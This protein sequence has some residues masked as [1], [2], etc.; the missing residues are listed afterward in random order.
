MRCSYW[1]GR[2]VD[3]CP[4]AL[5]ATPPRSLTA[6]PIRGGSRISWMAGPLFGHPVSL[7]GGCEPVWSAGACHVR[8]RQVHDLRWNR[9]SQ[10]EPRHR[11]GGRARQ[12]RRQ[13]HAVRKLRWRIRQVRSLP[14]RAGRT[15]GGGARRHGSHRPLLAA[16][17]QLPARPRLRRRRHQS[18]TNRC[19]APLQGELSGQN[20]PR[21]LHPHSRHLAPWRVSPQQARR[22]VDGRAAPAH[23]ASPGSQGERRRPQAPGDSGAGPGISRVRFHLFRHLRGEL[24]GVPEEVPDP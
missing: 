1:R 3:I 2:Y 14:R 19:D 16:A 22:R 18:H 4:G 15:C 24:Q 7:S 8:R 20:R 5:I 13:A 9:R 6:C 12:G 11:C 21:R 17:V 23:T 10:I